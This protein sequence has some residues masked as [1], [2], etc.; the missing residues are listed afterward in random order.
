MVIHI[1][2]KIGAARGTMGIHLSCQIGA[3]QQIFQMAR[4]NARCKMGTHIHFHI[5]ISVYSISTKY[6]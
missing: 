3:A 1:S 6:M 4:V 5:F 2:C